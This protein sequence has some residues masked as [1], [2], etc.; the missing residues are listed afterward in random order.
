[1]K[2]GICEKKSSFDYRATYPYQDYTQH[3]GQNGVKCEGGVVALLQKE[4]YIVGKR[5]ECGETTAESRDEQGTNG[6]GD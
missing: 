4:V 1:M 3:N 6:G 2:I 5:R